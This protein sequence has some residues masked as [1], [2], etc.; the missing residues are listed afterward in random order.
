M[1]NTNV[2]SDDDNLVTLD[3]QSPALKQLLSMI[4]SA[5]KQISMYGEDH[6]N[7]QKAVANLTESLEEFVSCYEHAICVFTYDAA[8]INQCYYLATRDSRD[9][10]ERLRARGVMAIA[11][12]GM[13]PAEHI[14]GFL[15]FLHEEPRR[16][17]L[18]CGPSDYLYKRGITSIVMTESIYS[19]GDDLK[20]LEESHWDGQSEDM[21]IDAVIDWLTNKDKNAD[22]QAPKF[23]ITKILSESDSAIKLIRKTLTKLQTSNKDFSEG[24]CINEA[25]N[26]LKA[27]FAYDKDEWDKAVPQL[28]IA[29]AKLPQ[30]M[31]PS[32]TGFTVD[33]NK[34]IKAIDLQITATTEEA[35]TLVHDILE[36]TADIA[37]PK[38]FDLYFGAKPLGL[39]SSWTK[40]LQPSS[41]LG[42][43]GKTLEVL[44]NWE[45]NACEHGR[46]A[47]ALATLLQRAVEIDDF[48]SALTFT[49]GL[50]NVAL[51]DT[52]IGW[53]RT[54]ILSALENIDQAALQKMIENFAHSK[55]RHAE[56]A[57]SDILKLIP[58][59]ALSLTDLLG[60]RGAENVAQALFQAFL[61]L[62]K[63]A[64]PVISII[65][66]EGSHSAKESA[67]QLLVANAQEW[68]A[69]EINSA[70]KNND[71]DFTFKALHILPKLKIPLVTQT[72]L[73]LL[74]HNEQN[75]RCAALKALGEIGDR[76]ALPQIVKIALHSS[77]LTDH[78]LEQVVAVEALGRIGSPEA[79]E[80][81]KLIAKC[82][83]LIWR[84]RFKNVR[85]TAKKI[86][87]EAEHRS[88][89]EMSEAA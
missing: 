6:P 80:S 79:I 54:N 71:I 16:I 81:L 43:S 51:Q 44:M 75:V 61:S 21:I 31:R 12:T 62:G 4:N 28:R 78:S 36:D 39:L 83:P 58:S 66:R 33:S 46:I 73:G 1:V 11:F 69:E 67:L 56:E 82:H 57:T 25:L 49:E 72:C 55:R 8:I 64:Q 85:L 2:N 88:H 15:E 24:E 29:I 26:S 86:V 50:L 34:Q 52:D 77:L 87:D 5:G 22:E 74:S 38:V 17:R 63:T 19:A 53:Q 7:S 47:N 23:P 76:S 18:E 65:L 13:P 20:S 89:A 3:E 59:L 14:H 37:P 32:T 41:I 70:I 30:N 48:D 40:E 9:M 45:T 42:S 10:C 35:E 68:A 84:S 27:A 60:A